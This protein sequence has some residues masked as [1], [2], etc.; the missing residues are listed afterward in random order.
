MWGRGYEPNVVIYNVHSNG[1]LQALGSRWCPEPPP[2]NKT[3]RLVFNNITCNTLL[4]GICELT[5][6]VCP[7]DLRGHESSPSWVCPDL[8]GNECLRPK[9]RSPLLYVDGWAMQSQPCQQWMTLFL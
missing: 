1:F 4:G 6:W 8:Q 9:A 2:G 3:M 7:E 5:G